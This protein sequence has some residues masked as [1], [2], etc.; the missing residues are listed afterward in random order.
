[1]DD[2]ERAPSVRQGDRKDRRT[3]DRPA[4]DVRAEPKERRGSRMIVLETRAREAETVEVA[5]D[6]SGNQIPQCRF[7]CGMPASM[8]GPEGQREH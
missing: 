3:E 7:G 2:Q 6:A 1:M 4:S 5:L 8:S